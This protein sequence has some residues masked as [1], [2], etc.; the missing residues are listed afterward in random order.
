MPHCS[1]MDLNFAR[2]SHWPMKLPRR[3]SSSKIIIFA[4]CEG[5][6]K[7]AI[8]TAGQQLW[9]ALVRRVRG[10]AIRLTALIEGLE[11][12]TIITK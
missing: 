11:L 2:S 5:A 6:A 12:H 1:S 10:K 9:T 7:P 3:C 4:T 8:V